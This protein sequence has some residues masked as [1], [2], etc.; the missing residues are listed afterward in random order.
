MQT[1][2]WMLYSGSSHFSDELSYK[3]LLI[4]S[5]GLKDIHFARFQHFL[6]FSEKKNKAEKQP[7]A[8]LTEKKLAAATDG[9]DQT[10]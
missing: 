9:R 5:Y 8:F 10:C 7:D 3:T 1:G 4:S 6:T 2:I